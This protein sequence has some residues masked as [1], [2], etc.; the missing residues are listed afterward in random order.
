[1]DAGS[2]STMLA[3]ASSFLVAGV[4]WWLAGWLS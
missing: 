1:M 3:G 2:V 4:A